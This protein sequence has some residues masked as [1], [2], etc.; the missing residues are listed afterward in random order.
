MEDFE[1]YTEERNDK[2]AITLF[3]EDGDFLKSWLTRNGIFKEYLNISWKSENDITISVNNQEVTIQSSYMG[4]H[5]LFNNT[6]L[7]D[8]VYNWMIENN[9]G[10]QDYWNKQ[11]PPILE[12]LSSDDIK[13]LSLGIRLL[14]HWVDEYNSFY[15][16]NMI[17]NA[18][19]APFGYDRKN[20]DGYTLWPNP[21]F[22]DLLEKHGDMLEKE[23]LFCLLD[24]LCS[25][26]RSVWNCKAAYTAIKMVLKDSTPKIEDRIIISFTKAL[27]HYDLGHRAFGDTLLDYYIDEIFPTFRVEAIVQLIKDAHPV[28]LWE[29]GLISCAEVALEK[30]PTEAQKQFLTK[31]LN[32]HS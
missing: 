5:L 3:E 17:N 31:Q 23:D 14:K 15:V 26:R 22:D 19:L 1:F 16:D 28:L 12:K 7:R 18:N 24:A 27:T 21:L 30:S 13:E 32:K 20:A 25:G 9:I 29:D 11:V 8:E 2:Y 4:I 6:V 10:K